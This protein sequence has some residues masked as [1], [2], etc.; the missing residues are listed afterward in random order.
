MVWLCTYRENKIR[1]AILLEHKSSPV[2]FPHFQLIRY[3][4]EI[5][6]QNQKDLKPFLPILPVI[7]YHGEGSWQYRPMYDYFKDIGK[8]LYP[9]IPQFDYQ[10]INVNQYDDK[11]IIS[12]NI[13]LLKNVLLA[14]RYSRDQAYLKENFGILFVQIEEW[15]N[16]QNGLDFIKTMVVYLFKNSKFDSKDKEN[17]VNQIPAP[18]KSK[19]KSTYDILVEEGEL[20]IKSEVIKNARLQGLSIE[21][22][23]NIVDLPSKKVVA[24]LK[25][26]GME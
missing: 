22:I 12:F 1:I 6:E 8:E 26:L 7:L 14:L 20:N 23:A 21:L 9:Y 3:M 4:L 5:W 25:K 24:I 17:M 16:T 18:V 11:Q 10:L 15:I 19:F 2:S 13:G